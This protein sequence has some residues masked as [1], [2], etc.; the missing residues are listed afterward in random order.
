MSQYS[1]ETP[2]KSK[3]LDYSQTADS[4][5]CSAFSQNFHDLLFAD[6][7][8]KLST[9][10]HCGAVRKCESSAMITTKSVD[11][12]IYA[13]VHARHPSDLLLPYGI[14][15]RNGYEACDG[16]EKLWRV[17]PTSKLCSDVTAHKPPRCRFLGLSLYLDFPTLLPRSY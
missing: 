16:K 13:V 8:F 1:S 14:C 11:E 2:L 15:T 5:S 17:V 4:Q 12:S 6:P 10:S 3:A 9:I 7:G